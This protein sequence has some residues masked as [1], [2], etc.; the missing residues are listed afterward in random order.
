MGLVNIANKAV[1][2]AISEGADQVEASVFKVD[3][4]LTRYTKNMIHQNVVS[5]TQYLNLDLVVNGNKLG[6]TGINSVTDEALK[7][8]V[9]R[10][11]KIA[12][13]SSPDPEFK[14]Y[15]S[16]KPIKPLP[17]IY[18]K[19]TAELSPEDRV[20]AVKTIIN[21]AMDYDKQVKWSAG[22]ISNQT[23]TFAI[24]NSLGVNAETK[25]TR[26][27]VEVN[28][29]AG[30]DAVEGSG[31]AASFEMDVNKY[32]YESLAN[33]AAKDAVNSINPKTIPI[34]EYEAILTPE[35]VATFTRFIGMLGFS[36][37]SY[38][39]GY[40]FLTDKIGSQVFDEKL[41]IIDD[42]RSIETY[43]AVPFD[44]EGT[45]KKMISLVK[46]GVP[47]N[48]VYDNYTANKDETESTGHSLPKFALGFFYRGV[49]MP[50]NMIVDTGDSKVEEMIED[51][52]KGIY[53]T[54]L[55]YVNPIRRDKAVIS[56]LT[57]DACWY[58]E[59][60]EIKHAIKVMRFTDAVPKVMGSIDSL[61]DK[62]TVKKTSTVTTPF[63][64]VPSFRFT[65]QSEF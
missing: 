30:D 64:K 35:S 27:T 43:N 31:Y 63:I 21:T 14:S 45:P 47:E 28:T 41:T 15:V 40:S 59:N 62:S 33:S 46:N 8:A 5:T 23:M 11:L 1:E 9:E 17:E 6:S 24:A 53:L 65:G 4:A 38:Q 10:A 2:L 32:D 34:G 55:H 19:S 57:R 13:V 7:T 12:K 44:G 49:P 54:R 25:A 22:S 48:L 20:E 56:G 39:E 52:K 61:G 37:K 16:P 42:G 50:V 18:Y 51:T 60:G 26:A 36:A 3:N 29:R 58:I